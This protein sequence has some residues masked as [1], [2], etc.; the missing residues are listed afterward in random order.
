MSVA[1]CD[2]KKEGLDSRGALIL[3]FFKNTYYV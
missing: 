1:N 2:G 3:L